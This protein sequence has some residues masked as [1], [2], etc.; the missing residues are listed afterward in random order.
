MP[1]SFQSENGMPETINVV[2][3]V[4]QNDAMRSKSVVTGYQILTVDSCTY[5]PLQTVN[6]RRLILVLLEAL[7]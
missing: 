5:S 1:M 4:P 7:V 2:I 6:T 3:T